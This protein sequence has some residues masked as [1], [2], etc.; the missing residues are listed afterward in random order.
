MMTAAQ[1]LFAKERLEKY[2]ADERRDK[3]ALA[4]LSEWL[5]EHRPKV[6]VVSLDQ[7]RERRRWL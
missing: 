2:S 6:K 5:R 7:W 3:A 1:W 4:L